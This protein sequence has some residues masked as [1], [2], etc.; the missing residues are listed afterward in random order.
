M[1]PNRINIAL[2]VLAED[3]NELHVQELVQ[4]KEIIGNL[5]HSMEAHLALYK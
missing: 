1:Y 2:L 4:V 3:C 5:I